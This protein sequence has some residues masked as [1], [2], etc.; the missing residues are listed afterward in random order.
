MIKCSELHRK[1]MFYNKAEKGQVER[2][3]AALGIDRFSKIQEGLEK[4]GRR[5]GFTCIFYGTPGTGKTE[6]AYQIALQTGRD[7]YSVDFAGIRARFVGETERNMSA[8]F[9]QYHEICEKSRV[10]PI[11][12]FN[13]ADSLFGK[14][15]EV[16]LQ[17]SDRMENTMINIL[18][19]EMEKF[20]GIL[21]ATTNLSGTM[22]EAFE[23]RFLFKIEFA[24]PS[25]A[26][27][28]DIWKSM[29]PELSETQVSEI[30]SDFELSG[31]QIDNV[32]KKFTIEALMDGMEAAVQVDGEMRMEEGQMAALRKDCGEE[33]LKFKNTATTRSRVGFAK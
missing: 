8:V 17:E 32:V 12:L 15:I 24:R 9:T 1:R 2:L 25:K 28:K 4:R 27:R 30:A 16:S 29:L 11:L 6:T 26:A 19:Q 13:E 23:R 20:E 18:L 33:L 31:G 22:D 3:G 14:R 21:I 10:M 5:K 7:I